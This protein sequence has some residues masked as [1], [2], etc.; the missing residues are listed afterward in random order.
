MQQGAE[1]KPVRKA[2]EQRKPGIEEKM[3]PKPV[4]V[5]AVPAKKLQGKTALIT[6]G[7]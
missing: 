3:K 1:S 7:R 2:Q 4:S 5:K 6:G